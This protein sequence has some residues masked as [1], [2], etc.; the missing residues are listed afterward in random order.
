MAN[1]HTVFQQPPS[2]PDPNKKY[3]PDE[4]LKDEKND[5]VNSEEQEKVVNTP[6]L[7]DSLVSESE[8]KKKGYEE[9]LRNDSLTEPVLSDS[10]DQLAFPDEEGK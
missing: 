3:S 1:Q 6:E 5:I 9:G 2:N 4:K 10:D 8:N 7:V